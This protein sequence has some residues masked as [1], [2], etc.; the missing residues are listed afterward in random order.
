MR[1][2]YL[3]FKNSRKT[4]ADFREYLKRDYKEIF[5]TNTTD[6]VAQLNSNILQGFRV[7]SIQDETILE[8]TLNENTQ[9]VTL[10]ERVA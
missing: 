10:K 3:D 5:E 4:V 9:T 1:Q 7:S 2:H 8:Y 6:L